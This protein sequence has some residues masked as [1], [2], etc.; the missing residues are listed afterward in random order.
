MVERVE[1]FHSTGPSPEPFKIKVERGQKGGYGWE[2]TVS[3][4]SIS[5]VLELIATADEK[6]KETYLGVE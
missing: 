4:D 3:G 2:I 1:H 6:L 5:H